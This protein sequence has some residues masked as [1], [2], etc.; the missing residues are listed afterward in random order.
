MTNRLGG[1]RQRRMG[2]LAGII[3]V[4]IAA[5][6]T[7][8]AQPATPRAAAK[9][10]R[11]GAV[12][13]VIGGRQQCLRQGDHCALRSRRQYARYGF[14]CHGTPARLQRTQPPAPGLIAFRRLTD[15]SGTM[16]AIFTSATDG[17]HERPLTKPP[18]ATRDGQPDWAPDG[19]R[20]VFTRTT[21]VSSQIF[22]IAANGTGLSPLT[23]S[24]PGVSGPDNSINGGDESPSF[25][26]DGS[27][28]AYVH[29]N[30]PQ[31]SVDG[32]VEHSNVFIMDADGKNPHQA[33]DLPSYAG[34]IGGVQWSPDGTQFV[35]AISNASASTP[36]GGTALFTVNADGTGLTQLTPW[37]LGA[38][39]VP[40]WSGKAN[41][42]AFRA[43]TDAEAGIGNFYTVHPDGTSLTEITHFS[44]TTISNKV[45]F[46][47]DGKWI[48]FGK[49]GI[50]GAN[51]VFI[52]K[53]NGTGIRPVTQTPLDDSAPDW[54]H[55]P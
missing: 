10:C 23:P 2:L 31:R 13:G 41:L 46:S 8:V 11:G 27:H 9:A 22:S 29:L 43:V 49:T 55:R 1:L 38:G 50:Q 4:S 32:Q 48:V 51:D 30:G 15:D 5:A 18:A 19:K 36:S 3:A 12:H 39:G 42:I 37:A 26:P 40:D 52:A 47:P 17:S 44:N 33:T 24:T 21:E 6:S 45:G 35:F 14:D 53:A 54:G 16:G 34:D 25:S 28:I 7:A 20:L